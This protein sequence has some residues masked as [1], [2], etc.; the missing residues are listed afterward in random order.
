MQGNT[1]MPR[2]VER[3]ALER[4]L[5][6]L[7]RYHPHQISNNVWILHSVCVQV[8]SK[9][10]EGITFSGYSSVATMKANARFH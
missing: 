9:V 7:P 6:I 2:H 3:C 8:G 10:R 5:D 1:S 4:E